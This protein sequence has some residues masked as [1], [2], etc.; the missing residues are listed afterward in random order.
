[1]TAL[2]R[3]NPDVDYVAADLEAERYRHFI[4]V[5]YA[6]LTKLQWPEDSFDL[7]IC[8]HVLEH[9]PDDRKA[10]AELYRVLRPGGLGILQVPFST[11]LSQT[12]EDASVT[13]ERERVR[14]FG[15][16]DHI[17]IYGP[18]YFDRLRLAG[19]DVEIF[20]PI[21]HW[22]TSE[23]SRLRCDPEEK[24]FAVRK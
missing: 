12:I 5:K 21:A 19:F 14:R 3:K 1:L 4:A 22:G 11:V 13:C 2:I 16:R 7:I 23:I 24:I 6:D 8:N 10:M 15:Q 9:I 20:D 17:R 18:D